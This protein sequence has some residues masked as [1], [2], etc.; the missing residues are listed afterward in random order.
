[1][2]FLLHII[3]V[4]KNIKSR[5]K[6]NKFSKAEIEIALRPLSDEQMNQLTA[7]ELRIVLKGEQ[8]FRK[9]YQ[10]LA[11]EAIQYKKINESL[12]DKL[13]EING[14]LV[15][16]KNKLYLPSSEKLK[17]PPKTK[18]KDSPHGKTSNKKSRDLKEKYPNADVIDSEIYLEK[19]PSC[20]NCSIEMKEMGAFAESSCIEVIEKKYFIKNILRM[21]YSCPCCKMNVVTAPHLPRIIPRSTY[22]DDF[23]IDLV[24][25]KYCDLLPIERYMEMASRGGFSGL[26]PQSLHELSMRFAEFL[27]PVF[28][29]IRTEVLDGTVLFGDETTHKMLETTEVENVD[30]SWY[31]WCFSIDGACFFETHPTRSGSVAVDILSESG[32]IYFMSDAYSGYS[33]GIREA[34]EL[35]SLA[36]REAIVEVLCNAHARREFVNCK[37]QEAIEV[38]ELYGEIYKLDSDIKKI[39]DEVE[40][41]KLRRN[42]EKYFNK[43]KTI[44]EDRVKKTSTSLNINKASQ[45]FLNN[46][47]KLTRCLQHYKIPLDNNKSERTLRSAVIGRKTW[48]GTHSE[49][50][51]NA[52]AVHFTIVE[53]CKLNKVNPRHYYKAVS[54]AILNKKNILTPSEYRKIKEAEKL[55]DSETYKPDS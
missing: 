33:R 54:E 23:I 2:S 24:V 18:P 5:N 28:E 43:I 12:E 8:N 19:L 7:A 9:Y 38:L 30:K 39:E 29:L 1:L 37:E 47:E 40:K 15:R 42:C 32:C 51:A 13:L 34:N 55:K 35:R 25:S 53:S 17:R 27:S 20:E 21:K 14:Q 46:F 31:T 52:A 22:S 45:Y 11:E 6:K 36:G 3:C 48:Y 26:A 4:E 16:I 44:A 10:E 50:G 49:R 41:N